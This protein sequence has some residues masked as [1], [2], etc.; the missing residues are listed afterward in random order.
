[1]MLPE[2]NNPRQ[3]TWGK[4]S[5]PSRR[6]SSKHGIADSQEVE[7]FLMHPETWGVTAN[8]EEKLLM[9]TALREY[10]M[11]PGKEEDAKL[12]TCQLKAGD[13]SGYGTC[14]DEAV[15]RYILMVGEFSGFM[16]K[17]LEA[18]ESF[19]MDAVDLY[20]RNRDI[21]SGEY[22]KKKFGSADNAETIFGLA[23][24]IRI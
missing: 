4:I 17:K 1:M 6:R 8:G 2:Q 9:L 14:E 10:L 21:M 11:L 24:A 20:I 23:D 16:R 22:V 13:F 5:K 12:L 18:G 15:K 7:T 19:D 3:I